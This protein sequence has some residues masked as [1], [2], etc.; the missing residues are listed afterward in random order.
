MVDRSDNVDGQAQGTA[1]PVALVGGEV[2]HALNAR[3]K[4]KK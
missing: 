4:C 2:C 3:R 1:P